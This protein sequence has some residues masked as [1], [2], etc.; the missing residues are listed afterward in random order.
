METNQ[1][2]YK[3]QF[4]H[5]TNFPA[6]SAHAI[7][8]RRLFQGQISTYPP[9]IRCMTESLSDM[10]LSAAFDQSPTY[11]RY[12]FLLIFSFSGLEISHNH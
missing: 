5:E 11:S 2:Q 4:Q 8:K 1:H 10:L 6:M 7:G 12:F 9:A 3:L